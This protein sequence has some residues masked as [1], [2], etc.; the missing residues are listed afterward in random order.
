M[1]ILKPQIATLLREAGLGPR[2][3]S[4]IGHALDDAGLS[5]VDTL[6]VLSSIV[7]N[8]GSEI[9]KLRAVDLALKV[10]GLLKDQAAPMPS[11]T[12]IINDSSAPRG[13]LGTRGTR[14]VNPILIPREIKDLSLQGQGQE[15][16]A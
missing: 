4:D 11:I 5:I 1:P 16:T 3:D 12:V 10:R 9:T 7:Q 14:G 13:T 8:G 15:L 6:D 2:H